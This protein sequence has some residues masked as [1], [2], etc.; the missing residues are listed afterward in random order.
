MEEIRRDGEETGKNLGW[1]DWGKSGAERSL[2]PGA[3]RILNHE[4]EAARSHHSE[5]ISDEGT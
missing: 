1:L 3:G 5:R 2:Y 4:T